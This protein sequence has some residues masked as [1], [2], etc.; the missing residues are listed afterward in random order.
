MKEKVFIYKDFIK[1]ESKE[2]NGFD[3]TVKPIKQRR[4]EIKTQQ[5]PASSG[6]RVVI[7]KDED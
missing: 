3:G 4:T 2:D 1:E 5:K 7:N 6:R